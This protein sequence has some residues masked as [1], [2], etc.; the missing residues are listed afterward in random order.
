MFFVWGEGVSYGVL[1]CRGCRLSW[2]GRQRSGGSDC[3]AVVSAAGVV[4]ADR[5]G[6]KVSAVVRRS[7]FGIGWQRLAVAM[8]WRLT[9]GREKWY[10]G[11]RN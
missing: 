11:K 6:V 7:R 1:R 9:I 3:R 2:I 8:V 10:Y 4:V 5:D